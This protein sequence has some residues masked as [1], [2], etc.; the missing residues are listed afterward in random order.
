MNTDK[1][2]RRHSG[3]VTQGVKP[4]SGTAARSKGMP[5]GKR[6]AVNVG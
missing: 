3:G 2:S 6:G 4:E 1:Q 5:D